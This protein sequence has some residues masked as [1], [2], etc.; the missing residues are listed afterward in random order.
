MPEY[1]HD[2]EI[3]LENVFSYNGLH[4]VGIYLT[5]SI[6]YWNILWQQD[7]LGKISHF[8]QTRVR[9]Q[10][11]R[12][13]NR[14]RMKTVTVVRLKTYHHSSTARSKRYCFWRLLKNIFDNAKF[15]GAIWIAYGQHLRKCLMFVLPAWNSRIDYCCL[16]SENEINPF[17]FEWTGE[18]IHSSCNE[19]IRF[20]LL[21]PSLI[22]SVYV[23]Y[24]YFI[25]QLNEC[26]LEKYFIDENSVGL[27]CR[28]L[29]HCPA[30]PNQ[31]INAFN[32][33]FSSD[34][35]PLLYSKFLLKN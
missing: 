33:H 23:Q 14:K 19:S 9:I 30:F 8:A 32:P 29:F 18:E 2:S 6:K 15:A 5:F 21:M 20:E 12:N 7:D 25:D 1:V 24:D 22:V 27:Y 16:S 35:N 10:L 26:S 3:Y 28:V 17:R 34:L 31:I 13:K 11:T 4:V